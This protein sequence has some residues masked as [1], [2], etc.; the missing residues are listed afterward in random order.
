MT[1]PI[2]GTEI[3]CRLCRHHGKGNTLS[4]CP[5]FAEDIPEAIFYGEHD[6]RKPYP[7]DNGYR[8]E[9]IIDEDVGVIKE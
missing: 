4:G 8:F 9:P 6:H 1:T 3:Q 5:G 7:G 2:P